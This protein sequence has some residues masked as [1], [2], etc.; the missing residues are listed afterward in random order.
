MAACSPS[1][2][3]NCSLRAGS[4]GP[5]PR[6]RQ[7]A[8]TAALLALMWA[9]KMVVQRYMMRLAAA[10]YAVDTLLVEYPALPHYCQQQFY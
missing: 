1:F 3:E 7:S 4:S 5:F 6:I 9:A 10:L 8:F 2:D